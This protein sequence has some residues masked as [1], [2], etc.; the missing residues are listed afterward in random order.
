MQE[1]TIK[2]APLLQSIVTQSAER[3]QLDLEAAGD[4]L[5]IEIEGCNTLIITNLGKNMLRVG[6][7][8]PDANG[9][10]NPDHEIILFIGDEEWIPLILLQLG[11]RP[12]R[13][14]YVSPD[15]NYVSRFE[16]EAQNEIADFCEEWARKL[17]DR[18]W[19]AAQGHK[20]GNEDW[21]PKLL[22]AI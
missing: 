4:S 12:R 14:A 9:E 15:R 16:A 5:C 21:R 3:F 7:Y 10:W 19:R 13:G 2:R 11:S 22:S 8:Y 1:A 18:D 20:T 17:D 6:Q